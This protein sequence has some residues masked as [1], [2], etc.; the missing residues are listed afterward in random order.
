MSYY[1]YYSILKKKYGNE[2][3]DN[4]KIILNIIVNILIRHL[5][6]FPK[7]TLINTFET[8]LKLRE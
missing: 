2:T 5:T 1:L 7:K 8:S 3:V 4:K 6:G